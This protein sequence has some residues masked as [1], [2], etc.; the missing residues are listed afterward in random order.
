MIT[1]I[2][3]LQALVLQ[4]VTDYTPYGDVNVT[5]NSDETLM[6]FNYKK[7]AQYAGRWNFFER[8][9]RGLIIDTS[10]GEVVARPFDKFFNYGEDTPYP[11]T[12]IVEATEKIDGSLGILYR[13]NGEYRIATRGSF[14][15]DQALWAT[16]K[17]HDYDLTDLDSDLTLLFEIVYPANRVVVDYGNLEALILIGARDRRNGRELYY[18]ELKVLADKYGFLQPQ[19]Y[20]FDSIE[21]VLESA[22]A[23]SA[24]QEG[25]VLRYSDHRRFKVKGDAYKV[26]HKLLTGISFKWVLESV[27]AGA[28]EQAIEGVPDEFLTTVKG[29]KAEI[30]ETVTR[31][32]Q[33]VYDAWTEAPMTDVRKEYAQWVMKEHRDLSAYLF[34]QYDNKDVIPLIYKHAFKDRGEA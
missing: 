33:Q 9:S 2:N 21:A 25:W 10:S 16:N 20:Q 17:L 5:L 4:G 14:V 27:V 1:T 3:D 32:C 19:V 23:L 7:A 28:Y 6:L 13:Q 22:V 18:Q 8:I 30:D 11:N 15:S 29:Y 31:I 24:N 12:H 34:A 26:A